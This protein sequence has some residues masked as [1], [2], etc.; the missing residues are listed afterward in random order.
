FSAPDRA[1]ASVTSS[2]SR[3]QVTPSAA[4]T[5]VWNRPQGS[6]SSLAGIS[7]ST[8]AWSP[9]IAA[10]AACPGTNALVW[11]GFDR[12]RQALSPKCNIITQFGPADYQQA[13][14]GGP[15]QIG[16]AESTRQSGA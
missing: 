9:V 13:L 10:P 8:I 12:P 6:R 15:T 14:A 5:S 7:V 4:T 11:R 2:P 1:P 16:L 3:I